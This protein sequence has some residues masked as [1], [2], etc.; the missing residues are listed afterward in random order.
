VQSVVNGISNN[1][2]TEFRR[3]SL[4][5]PRNP[6]SR[7]CIQDHIAAASP[8]S[9]NLHRLV[10]CARAPFDVLGIPPSVLGA[11]PLLKRPAA[12]VV[13]PHLCAWSSPC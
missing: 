13:L 12:G 10:Q 5:N 8:V 2:A 1:K 11:S 6:G 9:W 7:Q 4:G 3:S